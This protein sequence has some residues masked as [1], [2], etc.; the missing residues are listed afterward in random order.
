[1]QWFTALLLTY[2]SLA[3]IWSLAQ[4]SV[5]DWSKK[6]I[7]LQEKEGQNFEQDLILIKGFLYLQRRGEALLVLNRL[8]KG[9]SKKDPRVQELYDAASDQFFF[10]ETAE[11]HSEVLQLL[12]DESWVEAKDKIETG[13]QKEPKHRLLTL[14]AI[15]L[16]LILTPKDPLSEYVKIAENNFSDQLVWKI[17]SAW[18]SVQKGDGKEAHRILSAL[19]S[20]DRKFFEKTEVLMLSY[21]QAIDLTKHTADWIAL[22]KIIQ[23]H[24]EWVNVRLWRL[25]NKNF[26][27]K[28]KEKEIAQLKVLLGDLKNLKSLHAK[29]DKDHSYYYMGLITVEKAKAQLDEI[30]AIKTSEKTSETN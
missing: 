19:W 4:D 25:K 18:M 12:K 30:L 14:R 23:K 26:A 9:P 29:E 3:P 20:S 15:Q 6:V 13:L 1:M 28:D 27:A 24:P 8:M 5:Q 17:Y 16:G 21:L 2:F 10:Q 11:L 22:S 7:E